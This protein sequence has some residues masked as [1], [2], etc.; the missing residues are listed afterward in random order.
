MKLPDLE[1]WLCFEKERRNIPFQIGLIIAGKAFISSA[2]LLNM[3]F[4]P[5]LTH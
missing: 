3:K 5:Y 4:W 1:N 2:V